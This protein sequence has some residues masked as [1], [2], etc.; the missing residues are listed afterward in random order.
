MREKSIWSIKNIPSTANNV[1]TSWD[2]LKSRFENPRA[3]I[4]AEPKSLFS[5]SAMKSESV[6]ALEA[7][8]N[9][10]IEKIEALENLGRIKSQT[11]VPSKGAESDGASDI[12]VYH[13][14]KKLPSNTLFAWE[15]P[16]A[17]STEYPHFS[18]FLEF[19]N[20]RIRALEVVQRVDESK[21]KSDAWRSYV[22]SNS[23]NWPLCSVTHK[24]YSCSEFKK[25]SANEQFK[26]VKLE[27][28]FINCFTSGHSLADC[29]SCIPCAQCQ[30]RHHTLLHFKRKVEDKGIHQY[31]KNHF[32]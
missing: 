24:L 19:L 27:N 13:C 15:L 5:I 6:N 23:N 16:M 17:N 25:K 1:E 8:R 12:L 18:G 28:L 11:I 9:H 20:S 30:S 2:Q 10:A 29:S 22:V 4:N 7:M 31:E 21:S 14:S 3:L 26:F 32:K